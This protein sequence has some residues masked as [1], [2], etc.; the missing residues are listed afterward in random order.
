MSDSDRLEL[1]QDHKQECNQSHFDKH[2]CDFCKLEKEVERLRSELA[3]AK[4]ENVGCEESHFRLEVE[5]AAAKAYIDAQKQ[6]MYSLQQAAIRLGDRL[7]EAEKELAE[8]KA[9]N[10]PPQA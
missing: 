5:L 6:S 2:N 10:T 9:D 7:D 8:A 4:A 3:E 1:C